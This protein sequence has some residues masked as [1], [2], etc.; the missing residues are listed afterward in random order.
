MMT[1]ADDRPGPFV[2]PRPGVAKALGILNLIFS[3]SL[4]LAIAA[5]LVYVYVLEADRSDVG[6][7]EPPA[8]VAFGSQV[9]GGR[10]AISLNALNIN[11]LNRSGMDDSRFLWFS[12]IDSVTAL[13]LNALMF[14]SGIGLVNLKR[15]GA[16]AWTGVAWAKIVRL[17]LFWGYFIVAVSPSLSRGMARYIVESAA[18]PQGR[19]SSVADV[20]RIFAT[21]NLIVAV[22]M[23]VLGSIYPAVSLWIIGRSGVRAALEPKSTEGTDQP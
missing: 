21:I 17:V 6:P 23:I 8:K 12:A 16:R 7:P 18:A 10:L 13:I 14:A 1:I 11:A 20:T 3:T 5:T 9:P 2:V 4:C 19:G 22:G 15:W